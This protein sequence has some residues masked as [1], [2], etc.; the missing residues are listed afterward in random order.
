MT[1]EDVIIYIK[2][3]DREYPDRDNQSLVINTIKGFYAKGQSITKEAIDKKI[4][5]EKYLKSIDKK[6]IPKETEINNTAHSEKQKAE[7]DEGISSTILTVLSVVIAFILIALLF[8][9][10]ILHVMPDSGIGMAIDNL[11]SQLIG[12]MTLHKEI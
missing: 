12:N 9:M 5:P 2:E 6:I 11:I 4:C 3:L 1:K 7:P 8:M 10:I